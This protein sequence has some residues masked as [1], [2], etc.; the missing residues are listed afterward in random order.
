M[1]W[2]ARLY[3]QSLLDNTVKCV[4]CIQRPFLHFHSFRSKVRSSDTQ[5]VRYF[6]M[7]FYWNNGMGQYTACSKLYEIARIGVRDRIFYHKLYV[8]SFIIIIPSFEEPTYKFIWLML[9]Y[10]TLL[11]RYILFR[12]K[13]ARLSIQIRT[14]NHD[15]CKRYFLPLAL[16]W[17]PLRKLLTSKI[18]FKRFCDTVYEANKSVFLMEACL[19]IPYAA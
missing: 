14:Q 6:I 9:F 18:Y 13:N 8:K 12:L 16:L 7:S 15:C 4:Y 5:K 10:L 17:Y 19:C 11:L 1:S 3:I 2:L